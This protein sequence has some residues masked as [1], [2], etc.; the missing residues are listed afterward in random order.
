VQ[1]GVLGATIKHL[2]NSK[3]DIT[4]D[5]IVM[6][7][8]EKYGIILKNLHDTT[9]IYKVS[10][11]RGFFVPS[12]D[13][14]GS[15]PTQYVWVPSFGRWIK[16]SKTASVLQNLY[17]TGNN[18][19]NRL[20]FINDLVYSL[21][22]FVLP[23]DLKSYVERARLI[24]PKPE[25][26]MQFDAEDQ[27]FEETHQTVLPSHPGE[28]QADEYKGNRYLSKEAEEKRYGKVMMNPT[29]LFYG[30]DTLM[31]KSDAQKIYSVDYA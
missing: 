27:T 21:R 23:L 28:V 29:A 19:K 5:N 11:L 13:I 8:K 25:E 10:F 2:L 31:D 22:P 18:M 17:L 26:S 6:V 3:A 7:A 12:T 14:I 16:Y 20:S 24:N 4:G 1:A 15:T 9:D 30:T